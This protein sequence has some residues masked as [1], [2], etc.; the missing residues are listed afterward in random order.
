MAVNVVFGL[1]GTCIAAGLTLFSY[2]ASAYQDQ[3]SLCVEVDS[4]MATVVATEVPL[5]D[6]IEALASRSGITVQSDAALATPATLSIHGEPI[7]DVLRRMLRHHNFTLHLVTDATSGQPVPG[8]RLSILANDGENQDAWGSQPITAPVVNSV[9]TREE[10]IYEFGESDGP[11]AIES[12]KLSLYDPEERVRSAAIAMLA[13]TEEDEAAVV[14]SDL[15]HDSDESI[16]IETIDA[17]ADIGSGVAGQY[18]QQALADPNELNRETAADYL[19]E[20]AAAAVR[21][22]TTSE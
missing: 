13:A 5:R 9:N 22:Q 1:R 21:G 6:V 16:R 15:L 11:A 14:L 8:S 20:F 12:L 10:A 3:A 18:L 17:L 4:G 19:A 7:P 2:L